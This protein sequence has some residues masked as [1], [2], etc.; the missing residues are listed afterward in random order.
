[1]TRGVNRNRERQKKGISVN[2]KKEIK[3]GGGKRVGIRGRGKR[4]EGEEKSSN[5]RDGK[6]KRESDREDGG[7]LIRTIGSKGQM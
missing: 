4:E 5:L 1:M 6:Y 2:E 7:R 3:K